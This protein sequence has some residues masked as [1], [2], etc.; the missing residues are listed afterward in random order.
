MKPTMPMVVGLAVALAAAACVLAVESKVAP[1]P[2]GATLPSADAAKTP[3]ANVAA[4][5]ADVAARKAEVEAL[6]KA[7]DLARVRRT[8]MAGKPKMEFEN[9]PIKD[10]LK[11][12]ADSGGFSVVF[13]QA[14]EEGGLDLSTRPV[15]LRASGMTYEEA[16]NLILPRE[17]GY[18]VEAG[19]VLVTTLEKSY[20]PLRVCVYSIQL[21]LAEI[22]DFTD[23]PRFEV[24]NVLAQAAQRGGGATG[25]F[26]NPAQPAT[27]QA[28]ATPDRIIAM[29]KKMVTNASDRRIAPW[30]DEGGPATIQYS[31]GK[32]I[33]SQTDHGQRA[34]ARLLAKIE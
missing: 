32:L 17:C 21:T 11:A 29:I 16:I 23:A 4:K 9:T 12:L 2:P 18:R 24:G 34:V 19:Y 25:L 15:S 27:T 33:V 28:T 30:D 10:A 14:L 26:T 22:P 8:L 3:A 5:S 20:L 13:D 6:R 7:Q 1:P 31:G